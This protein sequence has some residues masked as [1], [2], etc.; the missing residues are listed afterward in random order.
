MNERGKS[1]SPVV[2]ANLPN[3]AM[4]VVAEAG[5]ERGLA[6]GN[7]TDLTR[8]GRRAGP[9]VPSGLDRV[10]EVARRDKEAQ[11]TALLHHVDSNRLRAAYWAINPKAATGV[12]K[13]TWRDYGEDLGANL[14]NLLARVHSGTYRASPSRRAYISKPRRAQAPARHSDIGGQGPSAC[15][16][17]GVERRLRSGLPRLLLRV[18]AGAQPARC[19]GCAG[20]RC[21]TEEGE[22]GA[23]R[24]HPRL[25]HQP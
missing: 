24:G 2:P 25:F 12:D 22:L 8:P 20:D 10:R 15:R 1:D 4:H 23:R 3:K 11:F 5:E 19:V 14:Q 21:L 16:R 7:T 9:S 17:R 13:V 6:K 18:P